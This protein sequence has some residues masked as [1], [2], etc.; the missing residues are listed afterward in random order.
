MNV[1]TISAIG[2]AY[3][4]GCCSHSVVHRIHKRNI[5]P[6]LLAHRAAHRWGSILQPYTVTSPNSPSIYQPDVLAK[7]LSTIVLSPPALCAVNVY[8]DLSP[9]LLPEPFNPHSTSAVGFDF[10]TAC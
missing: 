7:Q 1:F 6:K 8:K 3:L 10:I 4:A 2:N 9:L 5:E